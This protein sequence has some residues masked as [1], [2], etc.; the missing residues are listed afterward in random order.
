MNWIRENKFLAGFFGVTFVCV[1][2]LTIVLIMLVG[3]YDA[4]HEK[5][6]TLDR[7][8]TTL[9][10]LQPYPNADNLKRYQEQTTALA[11]IIEGLEQKL[12]AVQFPP[13]P[14]MN[15]PKFQAKL[16]TTVNEEI[17]KAKDNNILLPDKFALGFDRYLTAPPV[18]AAAVPLDR[19]LTAIKFVFDDLLDGKGV[20]AIAP[21]TPI[22]REPLPEENG[23]KP[24]TGLVVKSPVEIS[25]VA[26]PLK[27]R[28]LVNDLVET[29]KQ[30]YII[31]LITI[32]NQEDKELSKADAIK[33]RMTQGG[34]VNLVLG[35]EKLEVTLYL[36]IVNFNPPPAATPAPK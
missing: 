2:A 15:P 14:A 18:E 16:Q 26:D 8:L 24:A 35:G 30:F 13:D 25:F 33:N 27:V 6:T 29:G 36:E 1:V 17:E 20:Q 28:K 19:E 11:A 34:K 12:S 9:H 22:N 10:N 3:T 32:R 31:R 5:F 7:Q 23:A 4:T 21:N